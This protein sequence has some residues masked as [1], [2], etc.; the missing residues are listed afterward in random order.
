MT[1]TKPRLHYIDFM[2]G[3]CILFI[4]IFHTW[5]QGFDLLGSH[6]NYTLESFRIPMYYFISGIFFK[7]YGGFF[8]FTR[9]KVN[10]MIVPLVF[11][12][13]LAAALVWTVSHF[14]PLGQGFQAATWHNLLHQYWGFNIPLWFLLSLFEVNVVYYAMQRYFPGMR[15]VAVTCLA[16]SVL[17]YALAAHHVRLPYFVGTALLGLPFFV[18]G[19]LTHRLGGLQPHRLDRWGPLVLLVVLAAIYPF[20]RQIDF[21]RLV[22]PGYAYLYLVPPAAILSL[23]WACKRLPRIPV[24]CYYGRYSLVVL[25]THFPLKQL[26]ANVLYALNG[27]QWPDYTLPLTCV[28]LLIVEL[29]IIWLLIKL[30]PRF[31]A[32]EELFGPG[33]R[34]TR[35]QSTR[36]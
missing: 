12:I 15:W 13:L 7:P 11:F 29:P 14:P 25:G 21:W 20:A 17:G 19:S 2:K 31:T 35:H 24:I 34:L 33:W 8:D 27:Q 6:V 1:T 16:L 22:M 28:I 23:L 3:L 4:V 32:Q 9:R 18:L 10:N 26:I 5:P 30:F 36:N